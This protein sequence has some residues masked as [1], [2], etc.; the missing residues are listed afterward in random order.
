MCK[1]ILTCLFYRYAY[2]KFNNSENAAAALS[3]RNQTTYQGQILTVTYAGQ[4]N[5]AKKQTQ[6]KGQLLFV[7]KAI[8]SLKYSFVLL[9]VSVCAFEKNAWV[10]KNA[11]LIFTPKVPVFFLA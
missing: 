4:E 8:I 1:I 9:H 2:V 5:R 10:V 7:T 11:I 6:E 3:R